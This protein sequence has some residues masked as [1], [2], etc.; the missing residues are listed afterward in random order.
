[1]STYSVK[2]LDKS[3]DLTAK[4]IIKSKDVSNT[5]SLDSVVD[6]KSVVDIGQAIGYVMLQINNPHARDGN[7][8]YDKLVVIALSESGEKRYYSTGSESF[9]SAF[10]MLWEEVQTIEE[11]WSI[12]VFKK[13]SKNYTGKGFLTCTI[14]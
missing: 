13:P 7:H 8:T 3:G 10:N 11:D 6:E 4:D 12:Q 2:V 5:I 1:M 14:I 9:I